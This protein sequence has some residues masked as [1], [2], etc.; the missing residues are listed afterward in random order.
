MQALNAAISSSCGFGALSAPSNSY[1]SSATILWLRVDALAG[2]GEAVDGRFAAGL[3]LPAG[4]DVE[5][6][7]GLAGVLLD[8][9]DDFAEGVEVEAVDGRVLDGVQHAYSPWVDWGQAK[10]GAA[11][12]MRAAALAEMLES[13][14]LKRSCTMPEPT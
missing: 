6:D 13:V 9:F 4:D 8:R 12:A 2:D 11:S 5:A 7:L 1:G 14:A 10:T 3:A